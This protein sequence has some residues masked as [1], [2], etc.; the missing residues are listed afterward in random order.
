ML[1]TLELALLLL[2][3]LGLG[4]WGIFSGVRAN[5][6]RG[7]SAITAKQL[8]GLAQPYRNLMG[9]ILQAH[10]DVLR[11]LKSAP[12][13]LR[14]DL[15]SLSRRVD[16]LIRRALPRAEQGTKL[17][18]FLLDLSPD[19]AEYASMRRAAGQI[20]VELEQFLTMMKAIRGKVY[21]IL[22]DAASLT[23]DTYLK[24]D[25]EDALIDVAALEEAFSA[26]KVELP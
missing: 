4:V 17:T 26:T 22:T 25:L 19:E 15:E 5:R 24:R 10:N 12:P 23:Q 2:A 1:L 16:Q 21:Q 9:E 20:E 11:Q 3:L 13:T 18:S 7:S 14:R 8:S 6:R